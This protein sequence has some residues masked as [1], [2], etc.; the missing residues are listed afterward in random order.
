[1]RLRLVLALVTLPALGC[2]EKSN[3]PETAPV[4]GTVTYKGKPV[5]GGTVTFIPEQGP[6]N[7]GIGD[8]QSDGT[9]SLTTYDRDDGAV[10][11]KHKVT[12]EVF[13]GQAGSVA[14]ALPGMESKLPSPIP[15]KYRT[16]STSPLEFEVKQGDNV[17]DLNLED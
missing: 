13:P 10:L 17:A 8:I 16:P 2:G 11:G 3:T 5:I 15:K 12:V 7:P 14:D 4:T 6:G 9:Y 1:M